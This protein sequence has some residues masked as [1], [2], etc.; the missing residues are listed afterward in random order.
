M[1]AQ[2]QVPLA[3]FPSHSRNKAMK[4]SAINAAIREAQEIFAR[5][6]WTLP[7]PP[8]WDVTDCGSGDFARCGLVLVNLAEE[9]EYSEKLI[10]MR[11]GQVVPMHTHRR[12]KEDIICRCGEMMMEL[13]SG[14][15]D[16]SRRGTS[17]QIKRSGLG[18]TVSEGNPF[19][20]TAGER[21]TL[22]PGIYHS[23][24]PTRS[25]TVIGEVSTANDDANDN[26][27]ADTTIARFPAIDEDEPAIVKLVNDR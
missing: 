6:G 2:R 19:L 18:A 10:Y 4:R 20:V 11:S 15:P 16:A 24:W 1:R 17:L 23:F 5:T 9:P 13:W 22:T 8:R 27:F 3:P 25:E 14:L 7:S 12:K 26:F 21:V